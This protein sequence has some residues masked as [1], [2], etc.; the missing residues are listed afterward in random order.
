M[1]TPR[2]FFLAHGCVYKRATM[3]E[4]VRL[5]GRQAS[6]KINEMPLLLFI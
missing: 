4:H 2:M 1:A 3:K 5:D 6:L